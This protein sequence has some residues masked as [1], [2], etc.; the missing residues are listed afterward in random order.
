MS[1]LANEMRPMN[2][3]DYVSQKGA[4]NYIK[5]VIKSNQHPAGIIITGLPGTGKTTLANLYARATLCENRLESEYNPC[6]ECDSCK[7]E[8]GKDSHPNVTLYRITEA[9]VFKE[10][11]SDLISISKQAPALTHDNIREDNHRRI[12]IIDELQNATRQSISPFLDSLEF[13]HDKVTIVLI[14]MDLDKLDHI[15][16]D[17]VESRCIELQLDKLM[18]SAI[19]ERLSETVVG[20]SHDAA[21]SIA[22]LSSG[23]MRKAWKLVEY[24][25]VQM[26]T[27]S[28]TS[29]IIAEQKLGGLTPEKID[30]IV[31][32]LQNKSWQDT[33]SLLNSIMQ[34]EQ[35]AV[36][37]FL[38]EIVDKD[39]APKGIELVSAL[40]VWLQCDY[41]SPI[42]GI[43]TQYQGRTL[44]TKDVIV[45]PRVSPGTKPA[46]E[47][48]LT[49]SEDTLKTINQKST[50]PISMSIKDQLSNITGEAV[51]VED[52]YP[53]LRFRKWSEFLEY[54]VDNN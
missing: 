45:V 32:S 42:L 4:T 2:F 20:L 23:N 31:D 15:V 6:G 33:K 26:A 46:S 17:A 44:L 47:I 41:K 40:S 39:L 5:S 7:K 14:S 18:Q 36:D 8:L 53:F 3:D 1:N 34:D 51:Q 25:Q 9:S 11:V 49:E 21:D 43:F 13:A 10:A 35:R 24:F 30:E 48:M 38:R 27:K 54:Y 16:R 28:I 37:Y 29:E 52:N 22:Y 50:R 12:I 19:K